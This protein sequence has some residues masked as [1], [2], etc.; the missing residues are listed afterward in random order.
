MIGR[1][2]IHNYKCLVNFE[3]MLQE[4]VLLLGPNGAGK[5]AVLEVVYGL[6][7]L[8]AGEIKITD[9][10]AFH[11]STLTRWQTLSDQVFELDAKVGEESFR[12]R[13]IIE[14]DPGGRLSIVTEE[15]LRSNGTNLFSCIRGKVQLF[16]DDGSEGPSYS[17]DWTE[18][19]LARVAPHPSN[20]RLTAFMNAIRKTLVCTIN[21]FLLNVE[22]TRE[23]DLLDRDAKNF[24]D[25]YRH[26]VQ[27][28]PTSA[29]S[30]VEA[31]KPVIVG[32]SDLRLPQFGLDSRALLIDFVKHGRRNDYDGK[33]ELWF[34]ELSDG[35]R[36]LI[37]LYALLHLRHRDSGVWLFIDEPDN[38]VALAEIQ[39]WLMELVDLCM[40]TPSQAVICSHHPEL[41]DYLGPESGVILSRETSSI[42]TVRP[43][44]SAIS[45][46]NLKL[47]EV[48]SRGWG[49]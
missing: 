42:T 33:Y 8:L 19:A 37:V 39:P 12:Y 35:Q 2:Y 10:D 25:W 24:V 5:T 26:A 9:P 32:L 30:L 22:S 38:Y 41:I 3:L 6:R 45:T 14:H 40:E 36:A 48:I 44:V 20:T 31:L 4:T 1:I 15:S 34:N 18:S 27:E 29:R 49:E 43:L 21:P 13:L 46:N 28:N 7:R 16:R 23:D 17:T 47:S 11:P